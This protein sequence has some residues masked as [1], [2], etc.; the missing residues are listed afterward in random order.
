MQQG[1]AM[2]QRGARAGREVVQEWGAR[3]GERRLSDT[4]SG[5]L[6]GSLDGE[7]NG[8]QGQEKDEEQQMRGR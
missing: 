6:D 1:R 3:E 4:G 2:A 8:R 5:S 7:P